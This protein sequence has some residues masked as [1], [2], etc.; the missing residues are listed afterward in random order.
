[1]SEQGS[2]EW[3]RLRLGKFTG[4]NIHKLM[5]KARNKSDIFSQTALTYI[6]EVAAERC[7]NQ[8][9][10]DDDIDFGIYADHT[11]ASGKAIA[12]GQMY[13]P[14]ARADYEFTSGNKVEEVSSIPYEEMPYFASSPDGVV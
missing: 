12:W 1:M 13:E 6:K 3:R 2:L 8:N 4:S 9:S 10:V 11:Q 14:K 5:G 7:L